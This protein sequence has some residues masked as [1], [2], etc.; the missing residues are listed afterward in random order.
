MLKIFINLK[1][2][3]NN[4]VVNGTINYNS[5]HE[6]S[7]MMVLLINVLCFFKALIGCKHLVQGSDD[8]W[9]CFARHFASTI[10]HPAGSCKMAPESDPMGVVDNRLR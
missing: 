3:F 4:V 7:F 5:V 9:K 6:S 1:K 8:Y 2:L 10:Y